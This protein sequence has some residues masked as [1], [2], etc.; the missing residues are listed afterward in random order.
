MNAARYASRKFI[1]A[2]LVLAVAAWANWAEMLTPQLV[3]VL[4]WV[5]GLYFG[6]NVTQ[7]AGEWVAAK[8]TIK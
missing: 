3:D 4:K 5:A 7:K 8:V 2:L 6:F 1:L